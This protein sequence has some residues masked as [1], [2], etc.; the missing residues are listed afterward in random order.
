MNTAS[1]NQTLPLNK[2]SSSKVLSQGDSVFVRVTADKGQGK[3]EAML[4]GA[5]ITLNSKRPLQVGSSFPAKI[6]INKGKLEII[7]SLNKENLLQRALTSL[8]NKEIAGLLSASGLPQNNLSLNIIKQMYQL[9][10]KMDS[11]S[12][13]KFYNL[14]LKFK[15]KEKSAL[16]LLMIFY[17]KKMEVG[18]DELLELLSYLDGSFEAESDRGGNGQNGGKEAYELLKRNNSIQQGW[19]FY[20]FELINY[21]SR[22]LYGKGCIKIFLNSAEK[23]EKLNFNCNYRDKEYYFYIKYKNSRME[24][25]NF[26]IEN[27]VSSVSELE[28]KISSLF[29]KAGKNVEVSWCQKDMFEV[30]GSDFEELY[31]FSGEV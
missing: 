19:L 30:S 9:E 16:Q 12:L 27:E 24:K 28:K 13:K 1:I 4:S 25:V 20:P 22:E 8:P 15:G 6:N 17:K 14:A 23:I 2:I 29:T 26:Y 7:I 10:L 5:K 31:T 18:E 3:Y 21:K 11:F